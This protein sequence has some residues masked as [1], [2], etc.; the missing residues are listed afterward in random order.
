MDDENPDYLLNYFLPVRTGSCT[1]YIL[2]FA[3]PDRGL[4]TPQVKKALCRKAVADTFF[5]PPI[6]CDK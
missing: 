1:E 5:I 3:R 4:H 6:G 2:Q